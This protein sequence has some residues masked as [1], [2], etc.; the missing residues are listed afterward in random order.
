M[1]G[2]GLLSLLLI[3]QTVGIAVFI[4]KV[5][6]SARNAIKKDFNPI[7]GVGDENEAEAKNRPDS[8]DNNYDYM[9]D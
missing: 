8:A 2:I 1:S 4:C 7:Y 9:G 6:R 5:K 3:L